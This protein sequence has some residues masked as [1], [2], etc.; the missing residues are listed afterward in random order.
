M[1]LKKRNID[2]FD[3]GQKVEI[4][5]FC[6]SLKNWSRKSVFDIVDR[7]DAYK[8]YRSIFL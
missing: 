2:I 1:D 3:F 5:F 8:D 7:K 4:F 6:V